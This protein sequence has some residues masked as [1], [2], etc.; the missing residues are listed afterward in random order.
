MKD[1]WTRYEFRKERS[2]GKLAANLERP[3]LSVHRSNK[4]LYAQVVDD[5]KGSTLAYVSSLSKE[6]KGK[7]KAGKNQASAAIIGEKIAKLAIGKGVKQVRFDRG[8]RVY[9]GRLK[10]VADAARAA[11][12][13]F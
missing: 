9:H 5:L 4:H 10:A 3:R 12:L 8:G 1:K 13:E 2:R 11:G 7:A 6:V